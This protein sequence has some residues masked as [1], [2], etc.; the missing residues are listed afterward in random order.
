MVDEDVLE[1]KQAGNS[2]LL[3]E[4]VCE[5]NPTIGIV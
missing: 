5:Q 3:L 2:A 4:E 1:G